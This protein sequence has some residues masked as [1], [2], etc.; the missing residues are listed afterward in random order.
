MKR[1]TYEALK[2]NDL[3]VNLVSNDWINLAI[4]GFRAKSKVFELRYSANL[5]YRN[6]TNVINS[7]PL[8]QMAPIYVLPRRF[9]YTL[10]IPTYDPDLD[11][12]RCTFYQ[13]K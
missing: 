5:N 1:F 2:S 6:G 12:V 11:L 9:V 8:V 3:E 13:Y 7:S 10:R 4:W